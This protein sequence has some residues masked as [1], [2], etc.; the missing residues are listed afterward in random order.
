MADHAKQSRLNI[1][2]Y[3]AN[4]IFFLPAI[5]AGI[6]LGNAQSDSEFTQGIM[7][8]AR[9]VTLILVGFYIWLT[10]RRLHDT[11]HSGW[12]SF[13]LIPP[14][15]IFLLF[16]LFT[17]GKSQANKWGE[18]KKGLSIFGIRFKGWRIIFIILIAIFMLYLA[19]LFT[20]FLFDSSTTAK[21]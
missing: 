16:Y 6:A 12:F 17:A 3:L 4:S 18:P 14:F 7:A 19:G 10:A 15:T 13:G 9:M 5:L 8:I 21:Y 20:T 1:K 11:N 2:S